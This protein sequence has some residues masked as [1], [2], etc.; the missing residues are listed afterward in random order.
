MG[1]WVRYLPGVTDNVGHTAEEII[2]ENLKNVKKSLSIGSALLYFLDTK[3]KNII[4]AVAAE[5]SNPLIH[6]ITILSFKDYL[7]K[8]RSNKITDFNVK[9][10]QK[11]T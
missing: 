9:L 4:D 10:S 3:E 8:L 1:D 11:N 6:G 7:K 5:N 2:R